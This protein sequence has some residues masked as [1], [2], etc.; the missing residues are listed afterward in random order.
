L[1]ISKNNDK[2]EKQDNGGNKTFNIK[3]S[4]H[5]IIL[6]FKEDNKTLDISI[7]D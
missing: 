6:D 3:T 2:K 4:S 7:D 5:E 1:I